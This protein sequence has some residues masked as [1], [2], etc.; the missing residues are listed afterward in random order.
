MGKKTD[1]GQHG[2]YLSEI[3]AIKISF[4]ATVFN[5]EK[6]IRYLFESLQAQTKLPD[7][8]IIVDAKSTD[9]TVYEIE[10]FKK[11]L[12]KIAIQ[13]IE[14]KVNRSVG[15]NLA[16][17]RATGTIIVATDAGC[18]LDKRW[19]EN[20][21]SPFTDPEIDVVAGFYKPITHNIFEK[22]LACYTSVMKDKVTDDFLPSS[23]SIAFRKSAWKKIGGYPANLD[24]CEDLVFARNLKQEGFKFKVIKNAIVYWPQRKNIVEAGKQ[25]FNYA[26]GDGQAKYIR[27][28]TWLLFARYIVGF[29]LFFISKP[30]LT[31]CLLLYILWSIK[32]NYKYVKDI[33]ALLY[34]PMLQLVS[35]VCVIIGTAIGFIK[36]K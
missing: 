16:I 22:C 25:F 2:Q 30:A 26:M 35:D 4:I 10:Q 31:V 15:R 36:S 23:R 33:K 12:G 21:V 14:K 34:L 1:M 17:G 9:N 20:I 7:E 5:E 8:I 29:L 32:K 6:N 28:N 27:N 11:S 19:L 13:I 3:M 24:T 18:S